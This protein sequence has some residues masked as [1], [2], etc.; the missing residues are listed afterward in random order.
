VNR[1]EAVR[2]ISNRRG[3]WD[4]VVIGGGAT[5]LGTAVDAASRGYATLLLEQHDFAKGTSSRSTKLIHG[6]VRYLAQGRMGLVRTALHERDLLLRNA[7]HLVHDAR[8]IVPAYSGWELPC[9]FAGLKIYDLLSGGFARGRSQWLSSRQTLDLVPT[10]VRDRLRGGVMYHDCQ[11]DDARLAIAL[12][13]T[14]FDLGGTAV[15]YVGVIGLIKR[16]DKV[17]GVRAR[18]IET[19]RDLEIHARVVINATGVFADRIVRMDEARARPLITPSQG[20]HVVVARTVLPGDCAVV[21]PHTDDRRILFAIPWQNRVLIGTTDSPV[22]EPTDEPRPLAGELEFLLENAARYLTTIPNRTDFLSIFAGLRPLVARK[23]ARNTAGVSRDH[24]LAVS[25][26]GLVTIAG[27]KWTTYRHMAEKT[28]DVAAQAAG[29]PG[30]KS[31]TRTLHLHGWQ[32]ASDRQDPLAVY[33]TDTAGIRKLSNEETAWA[34]KLHERLPYVKA[35]VIWAARNEMARTVEDVLARRTRAL[36][37]DARTSIDVARTV[38]E[39]LATEFGHNNEW[40][41]RQVAEFTE[42]ANGYVG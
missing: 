26:S 38:A 33:G 27:G 10:L 16:E 13:R 3:P 37:L 19:G 40:V 23:S 22:T 17:A 29:L 30:R 35:E 12:A 24:H 4:V 18:D 28:V 14:L 41:A 34:E 20:I 7:P 15:N 9:Y 31:E 5:G 1:V 2:A 42:L 36:F 21:V 8:F 25:P 32:P 6:G 11:F 39:L